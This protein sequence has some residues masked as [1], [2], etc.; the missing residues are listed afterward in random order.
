MRQGAQG[1]VAELEMG[2]LPRQVAELPGEDLQAEW[3][4]LV[5]GQDSLQAADE[6]GLRTTAATATAPGRFSALSV[7]V[8]VVSIGGFLFGFDTGVISGALPYIRDDILGSYAGNPAALARWQELIVSAAIIAAGAGSVAGGWL[9]DR[10]GRRRALLAA[11]VLFTAGAG[12]MA[13]ARDQWWLIAGRALVGLGVGL[14]SVT[15]PIYIAECAPPARRASLVTVNVLLITTGQ[16]VAYVADYAFSF[17]PGTWRW[18]LGF[19]AL[20]S[21]AQ[22]AGLLLLPESP[23]WLAS[24]GRAAAAQAALSRLQSGATLAAVGIV[25]D[26]PAADSAAA[27]A[28]AGGGSGS[29]GSRATPWRLLLT[30]PVLRELHVGVGLQVLQQVA[31][32]NTVM[33]FTPTILQLAGVPKQAA[34]LLALVPSATN[35]L[36]T[37][38]GL[39]AIDRHGRRRLLLSSIAAVVLALAALGS[40]FLAAE[41]HSPAVLPDSGGGSGGGAGGSSTCVAAGLPRG[42]V[43]DSCT[44]CL[45][46]GC[47][48]CGGAGHDLMAAGTCLALGPSQ[49]QGPPPAGEQAACAPPRQLFLVGCPS[50]Y[51]WLILACLVAYLA[52][53][54][55]GL[56]P[57]PW[58]VNAEIYPLAVRGLAT[59][60][61]ATANWVSNAAVAQTFLTLTTA[62]GGSGAFFLYAGI[63]CAGFAWAWAV[64]PETNGLTLEQVQQLFGGGGAHHGGRRAGGSGGGGGWSG[65]ERK[66]RASDDESE[67]ERARLAVVAPS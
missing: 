1:S 64:L 12:A 22:L 66:Q 8:A 29:G 11:D 9:A 46:H 61:A 21:A 2:P 18:M 65:R 14:A 62:L 17:V 50:R 19:A 34:L 6:E 13:A 59:G 51:S 57:V 35:A 10:V 56:G 36:G 20:P 47:G 27:A 33:Y 39:R 24:R 16:F 32:I 48:F 45:R 67:P 25:A 43:P 26:S 44:A 37:L 3:Q 42:S 5:I 60:L 53:F 52:A 15:V 7:F 55:P 23:R 28:A 49:Q 40:A 30:R 58:A 54:S 63:A 4:P 31:G 38:V 41:R